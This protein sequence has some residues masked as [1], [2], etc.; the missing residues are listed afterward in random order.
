VFEPD[1]ISE[2]AFLTSFLVHNFSLMIGDS[3]RCNKN[4]F[5]SLVI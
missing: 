3:Q 5:I 2:T 4:L 1:L